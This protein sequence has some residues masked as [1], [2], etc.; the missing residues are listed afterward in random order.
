MK[1]DLPYF[2]HYNTTHDMPKMQALMA[3]FGMAGY[4]RYWILCEKIAASP[5]AT[6][7]ISNRAIKLA[8]ARALELCADEFDDFINFLSDSDIELIKFENGIITTEQLIENYNRVS[9]KRQHDRSAYYSDDNPRSD[10]QIPSAKTSIPRSENIQSKVN[11]S[12]SSTTTTATIQNFLEASKK[13]GFT[14]DNKIAVRILAGGL[15]SDWLDGPFN[16]LECAAH[17]VKTDPHYRDKSLQ[18]L[19]RLFISSLTWPDLQESFQEW[20]GKQQGEA[21]RKAA[22]AAEQERVEKARAGKPTTCDRCGAA[23]AVDSEWGSCP[24]CGWDYLFNEGKA[25]WEFSKPH[26]LA[27]EFRMSKGY[28]DKGM[29]LFSQG[30][31]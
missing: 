26:N 13:A 2:S 25:A 20:R 12:S 7:D 22:A 8:V 9:K 10:L 4:G 5:N 17:R 1:N 3:E 29:V 6:L 18:E 11:K 14:L 23:L 16:F 28:K 27:A 21:D 31:E 30:E 19:K 24:S 15:N